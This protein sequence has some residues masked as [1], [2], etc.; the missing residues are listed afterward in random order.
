[1]SE[2]DTTRRLPSIAVLPFVELSD[3]G[4]VGEATRDCLA[5]GIIEEMLIQLSKVPNLSVVAGT[6]GNHSA[7]DAVQAGRKLGARYV[8]AGTVRRADHRARFTLRLV[9]VSTAVQ[10]WAERYDLAPEAPFDRQDDIAQRITS[11]LIGH[12]R[13]A[14]IR[15]ALRKPPERL[16]AYGLYLRGVAALGASETAAAASGSLILDARRHL[17]RSVIADPHYAPA[18]ISLSVTFMASWGTR[19]HDAAAAGEY[20]QPSTIERALQSAE[21]AVS[22]APLLAE[23]HAQHGWCLHHAH[24]RDEA[25]QAFARALDLNDSLADGRYSLMLTHAGR[26]DEAVEVMRRAA[27][28]NPVNAPFH[29][30]FL[31]DAYYLTGDYQAA[32]AL[33]RTAAARAPAFARIRV[34]QAAAAGRLGLHDEARQAAHAIE[35]LDPGL[36]ISRYLDH[37]RFNRPEDERHLATGLAAAGLPAR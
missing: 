7:L 34:W 26:H 18:L 8:A 9:D 35:S 30:S 16:D 33:S 21:R 17:Q 37:V 10:I 11:M 25:M 20:R 27:R 2:P 28:L 15:A 3:H 24:R 12:V 4:R 13:Q 6:V 5:L 22:L 31:A 29:N 14:E 19:R 23:A 1:V 32:L 36:T